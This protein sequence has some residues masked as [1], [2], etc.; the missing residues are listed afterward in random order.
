ML[1]T[2]FMAETPVVDVGSCQELQFNL[3]QFSPFLR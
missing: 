2:L 3:P 1:H